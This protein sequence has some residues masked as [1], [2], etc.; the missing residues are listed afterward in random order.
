MIPE[1][2]KVG[3]LV[4]FHGFGN[5]M[6]VMFIDDGECHLDPKDEEGHWIGRDI[7]GLH[8]IPLTEVES[9]WLPRHI[10]FRKDKGK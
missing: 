10:D 4:W 1:W 9:H 7:D 6:K 2:F 3:A 8:N 5:E